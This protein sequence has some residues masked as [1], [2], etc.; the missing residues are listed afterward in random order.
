MLYAM[1]RY[2]ENGHKR[3]L[4]MALSGHGHPLSPRRR[5]LYLCGASAALPGDLLHS[6]GHKNS[7]GTG[8]RRYSGP[9]LSCWRSAYYLIGGAYL[10]TACMRAF[11]GTLTGAETAMPA[12]PTMPQSPLAIPETAISITNILDRCRRGVATW[13]P[14]GS[15]PWLWLEPAQSPSAPLACSF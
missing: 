14:G 5:L 1:L 7:A 15:H 8:M 6:P 12:D 9:S 10:A 11:A 3:Y 4:Y 2:L 13:R